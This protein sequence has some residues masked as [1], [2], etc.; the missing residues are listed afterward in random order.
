LVKRIGQRLLMFIGE[1]KYKLNSK[2][3]LYR[4]M[5]VSFLLLI[6]TERDKGIRDFTDEIA[7]LCH[8]QLTSES[9]NVQR[10]E[11]WL[12]PVIGA[13]FYPDDATYASQL[14]GNA[15]AAMSWLANSNKQG[16]QPVTAEIIRDEQDWNEIEAALRQVLKLNELLLYYQPKISLFDKKLSGMEALVRWNRKDKGLVSPAVFIPVAEES[17]LIVPIGNWVLDEACRQARLWRDSFAKEFSISVNVSQ[18]QLNQNDFC[19][20]VKNILQ[21]YELE[22]EVLDLEITESMLMQDPERNLKT[23]L[24]LRQLGVGLSLDDFGTGY[25]SLE[26]LQHFPITTLKIDRTFIKN[27]SDQSRN[28]A[29]VR[30]I[31]D[32][33][34]E[35]NLSVVAEG[36]ETDDQLDILSRYQCDEFQGFYFSKPLP[37]EEFEQWHRNY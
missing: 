29:V 2:I 22:P 34:H 35:L 5:G 17:G 20:V 31:I 30:T 12:R 14:I 9:L 8:D 6:H 32:L 28:Y 19:D 13:S 18:L 25:S 10:R 27:M 4:S 7:N 16:Y 26:Y 21:K 1:S 3:H 37:A 36:I 33:A 11:I 24:L 15:S 23:L